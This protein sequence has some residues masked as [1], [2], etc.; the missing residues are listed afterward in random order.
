MD[1]NQLREINVETIKDLSNID[2][3]MVLSV[4]REWLKRQRLQDKKDLRRQEVIKHNF[5]WT[6]KGLCPNCKEHEIIYKSNYCMKCYGK[7]LKLG[8]KKSR[9]KD[10]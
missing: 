9:I 5:K 1:E 8:R 7:I 4:R 10:N 6:S 2:K 3:G